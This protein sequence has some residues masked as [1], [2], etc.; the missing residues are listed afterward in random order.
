MSRPTPEAVAEVVPTP[1]TEVPVNAVDVITPV[2]G[3]AVPMS[4]VNDKVFASGVTKGQAVQQGDLLAVVD[5]K[6]VE[7]EGYDP[8]TV[9]VI[10][11]TK[12]LTDVTPVTAGPIG[13]GDTAITVTL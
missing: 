8:T 4:E 13:R 2:S 9:V 5:M 11:N 6:A 12:K 3:T 7:E 1:A 10:T